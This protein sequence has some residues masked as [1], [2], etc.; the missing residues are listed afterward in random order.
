MSDGHTKRGDRAQHIQTLIRDAI[1][2]G[3]LAP[4]SALRQ[5]EL[6]KAYD[7][8]RMPIREAFR[9]LSAEGLVQLIPNRGAIVAPIDLNDLR[10]NVEMREVSET[11]AIR[12]A[13]PHLSNAQIDRAAE[14]Q[15]Q[16]ENCD[17]QDFGRLNKAFHLALYEPSNRP[18][19]MAHI[20]SL[21]DIAERYLRFTLQ[22]LDYFDRSSADHKAI[23]EACYR[24]DEARAIELTSSHIIEAGKTLENYLENA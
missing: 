21:H 19:L 23:V 7:S 15:N 16:I 20:G 22:R 11:L 1:V 18:R 17:I 14:I 3:E 9:S 12:L 5:E 4:G 13:L 8:S 10:E 6:A 24:R 2:T